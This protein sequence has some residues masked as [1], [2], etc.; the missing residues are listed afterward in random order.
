MI[1]IDG[2][3]SFLK[4]IPLLKIGVRQLKESLEAVIDVETVAGHPTKFGKLFDVEKARQK[5]FSK[6]MRTRLSSVI[7]LV[8]LHIVFQ[9]KIFEACE[10]CYC[11]EKPVM[12]AVPT[13]VGNSRK[14]EADKCQL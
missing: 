10:R 4:S 12:G 1:M 3:N 13:F 14:S 6:S 7:Y 5:V 8:K 11:V 9:R 2:F